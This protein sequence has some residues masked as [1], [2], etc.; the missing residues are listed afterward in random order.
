MASNTERNTYISMK[1]QGKKKSATSVP[2]FS[3]V[4]TTEGITEFILKQNG[5]RVLHLNRPGTGVVTTNITYLVGAKDEPRGET[6]IAHMLEHMLFKPTASDIA[7]GIDS[8]AMQFE[9]ETGSI[10]NANTWKDRTTYYFSY[11]REYFERALSI[12]AER[13]TGV[14]LTDESLAPERNNVL[15]EYDMY[16]GD[17]YFALSVAMVGAAYHSHPYGHETIGHREDILSYTASSL[18]RFYRLYYRPDNAVLMIVGDI[19]EISALKAVKKYF[20]GIEKPPLPIPRY[21]ITEPKQEGLRRTSIV[22][23]SETNIVALGVKHG[24]FPSHGWFATSMLFEILAGGP[25]SILHK[26]LI[27]TGIATSL[28]AS[29]EPTSEEN[30]AMLTITLA[31]GQSHDAVEK[32]VFTLIAQLDTSVVTP[33]LKKVKAKILTDELFARDSSLRIVQEL[34][35]YT[36]AGDWT[37]YTKA[38][39]LLEAMTPKLI[40]ET[41]KMIFAEKT[42]TIGYFIGA[43]K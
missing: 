2:G 22:R 17:P 6:G 20:S 28:D 29:I 4:Q 19:D 16:N 25:E 43:K 32:K 36:A 14:V 11:P 26:A 38:P 5:L 35:E 18:D 27:D 13:I 41:A 3:V 37:Q 23:T 24:G 40:M 42:M 10:L 33:L 39:Q 31:E 12:E 34:T 9:R 30:I 15:S 7:A 1:E 8:A 21:A